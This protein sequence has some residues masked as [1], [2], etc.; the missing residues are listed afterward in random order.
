LVDKTCDTSKFLLPSEKNTVGFKDFQHLSID[1]GYLFCAGQEG[2]GIQGSEDFDVSLIPTVFD[3]I[4]E[5]CILF[6]VRITYNMTSSGNYKLNIPAGFDL[7]GHGT[8]EIIVASDNLIRA[9][10]NKTYDYRRSIAMV[11]PSGTGYDSLRD[12]LGD[13]VNKK[14]LFLTFEEEDF[15][16]DYVTPFDYATQKIVSENVMFCG[17]STNQTTGVTA[18]NPQHSD[19]Y[20]FI[21]ARY[22]QE[23]IEEVIETDLATVDYGLAIKHDVKFKSG[24]AVSE[25]TQEKRKY[26]PII[27][28]GEITDNDEGGNCLIICNPTRGV[29]DGWQA[30]T[31]LNY[32]ETLNFSEYGEDWIGVDMGA[33]NSISVNHVQVQYLSNNPT[34]T[35]IEYSQDGTTWTSID[36]TAGRTYVD[37]PV[38]NQPTTLFALI[39]IF[40]N[41]NNIKARFWRHRE[42]SAVNAT[43]KI[44]RI[45]FY[46]RIL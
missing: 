13:L 46:E 5:L 33:G 42:V 15:P 40:T 37:I 11:Y 8:D 1:R 34:T 18:N 35:Y 24:Y 39:E 2:S 3:I 10:K 21:K 43:V 7:T 22:G 28:N 44:K 27:K 29:Q 14:A 6:K 38:F 16:E 23:V 25:I 31:K 19:S 17:G 41:A 26:N 4:N 9:Y 45:Q 36:E 30:R 12:P 32:W 20:G